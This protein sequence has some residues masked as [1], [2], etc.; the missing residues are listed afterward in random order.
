[1][2][3]RS[4]ARTRSRPSVMAVILALAAAGV[5][6]AGVAL[7]GAA[8]AAPASGA[9]PGAPGKAATW[10]A[11]D[12]DGLGTA[13]NTKS[14]VWYTLN[15][16][17]LTEVFFPRVDTP[18]TRDTQLVVSDGT[19]FTDREDR[20]TVSRV[21]LTDSRSLIYQQVNTAK[22]GKYRITKTY[23]TDPA[24][25]AVLADVRFESLTGRPYAVYVLHD[26][27]L[28]LN[29]NDDTGRTEG[30]GLVAT[31]GVISSAV[32]ASPGFTKTSS[33]YADR[34]D[35]WTDLQ[36]NRRMDWSYSA[37][38][39]GNVVQMGQTRLT[40]LPGSQRLTL[41]L[42][43]DAGLDAALTTARASLGRGFSSAR[44]AYSSEW[45]RYVS[46]LSPVPKAAKAWRPAYLASVM[47]LA[48]HEDKTFR[49]GFV[50]AAS[51]PW[52]W[53][54]E[55]QHLPVYIAVWSRDQYQM[56]TAL[57]AAGDRAAAGRALDYLW[58]VQQRPDGSFPQNSR[59]DGEPVFGGLQMDE[60]AFPIVLSHQLG[61]TGSAEWARVRRSADFLVARGPRTDQERWENIGGYSPATIAAE[62]AGL[63]GAADIARRNNAAGLAAGYLRTADQWQRDLDRWTLT[64]NGPLSSE[65]YYLRITDNGDA[66]SGAP[67]QI[68]DGGPLVDQR[69]VIDPSFLEM[70]RLGVKSAK[71]PDI[72]STLRLIDA[73]L[74]YRTPNGPFW[75]RSSF[76]GYG[77]RR[78]GTQWEPVPAGSGETVGRGWPLLTGERGEYA[79]A[80]RLSARRYLDAMGRVAQDSG[81][82]VIAEQVWD[83]NPPAG[84]GRFTP[85][86]NTFSATPLA[87][88]HAQFIRLARSIDAGRPVETPRIVACRYKTT[89][90]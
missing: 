90:C 26:A 59:L 42:G 88:S 44:S 48:A 31:D 67:I 21:R 81:G 79:L 89:L 38:Q 82:Q 47:L 22:S 55:L 76:D 36:D 29:A 41:S 62:I 45:H 63:V 49:G 1:M 18:A 37:P 19:T 24:R 86:E 77:E 2:R 83:H 33:G 13:K 75:H 32:L 46:S 10:A 60:V 69:Q 58:T 53:A 23:V 85:G 68:A 54:N 12:K 15:D 4:A 40:G 66:N 73:K 39:R 87:W 6:S 30:G 65:P 9:A 78:D 51:R 8:Q 64:T 50:A 25:S 5:A 57:L 20:D 17:A 70:V 16:G 7:P 84:A 11:G 3:R 52:A 35:G 80:A 34:S 61:R 71:D 74:M 72:L 43:F 28:G 27:G 14:K 56:A